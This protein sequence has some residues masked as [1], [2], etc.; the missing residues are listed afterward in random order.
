MLCPL[1]LGALCA[2]ASWTGKGDTRDFAEPEG[3]AIVAITAPGTLIQFAQA[4][5]K[6]PEA[7]KADLLYI[8]PRRVK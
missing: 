5:S 3:I 7:E 6:N 8:P 2:I 1:R 4:G